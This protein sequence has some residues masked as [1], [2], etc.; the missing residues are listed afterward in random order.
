MKNIFLLIG[1]EPYS[2]INFRIDL[3][4][5]ISFRGFDLST[6]SSKPSNYHNSILKELN[7]RIE[8][9]EFSRQKL[10]IY[11]NLKVFFRL[12]YLYRIINPNLILAYTIKP[13]IWGGLASRF[14]KADFYA[15]VTGLGFTFQGKSV[16][17]RL[18]TKLVVFLYK[19][20]LKNTKAV[21]F[22]NI[23]NRD[24]FIQKGII[25]SFKAHVVNGSG[26]DLEKFSV[27]KFPN[28]NMKFLCISRLLKEKGLK[29]FAE[30]AKIVKDKFPNVNFT[31][32]GPKELSPDAVSLSEINSWSDYIDYKGQVDDVRTYIAV[33]HV[34]VLPSYHEGLPRSTLEAMAMGRPILTTNAVGCRD[35]VKNGI[36]GYKVPIKSHEHLVKKMIWFIENSDQVKQMGLE[37]RKLVEDKF[38]VHK[39]NK[40][41]LK[42]ME[43]K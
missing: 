30:A 1:A 25:P 7:I 24:E 11:S 28:G 34:F 4:K 6:I 43:I 37:S 12:I 21:I 40:E 9:L 2:L 32:V 31:L 16:K 38:D 26:V 15:L 22:Q 10:D 35:T 27:K 33:S 3:L 39:V 5:S 13:I 17:R 18:L 36:N 20:A 23:E 41:M 29:E 8:H 19:V 14:C 42:I